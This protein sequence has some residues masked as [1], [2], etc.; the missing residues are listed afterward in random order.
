M[1]VHT[2][3]CTH[4]CVH[5]WVYMRCSY[6]HVRVPTAPYTDSCNVMYLIC[7]ITSCTDSYPIFSCSGSGLKSFLCRCPFW[8]SPSI[9]SSVS[10]PFGIS[11][12]RQ[13]TMAEVFV[14]WGLRGLRSA[15]AEVCVGWGLHGLR[16]AWAEVCVGWG[17]RRLRSSW[18]EVC[19][20]WGLR[21]LMSTW[22]NTYDSYT[23][24]YP[25]LPLFLP[26]WYKCCC[27]G[28]SKTWCVHWSMCANLW[29]CQK[30]KFK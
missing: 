13:L 29:K 8:E 25:H 26:A 15:W 10:S 1:C 14:G 17:L 16:S 5:V 20:G 12:V 4:V 23:G 22:S 27:S 18:A 28:Q 7:A 6:I 9:F 30:I 2:Y 24:F 21:R 11:S 3:V 19:V